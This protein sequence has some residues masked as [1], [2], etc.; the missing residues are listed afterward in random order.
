MNK[1]NV[2]FITIV[3]LVA[4]LSTAC[5]A[6]QPKPSPTALP[7]VR[8]T[9]PPTF[10]PTLPPTQAASPT[11]FLPSPTP[12]DPAKKTV[13]DFFAALA[14]KDYESAAGLYSNFSLMVDEVTRGEAAAEL[15]ARAARGEKIT[16]W[17]TVETRDFDE[18]T[19]LVH[20]VYK[21][22]VEEKATATPKAKVTPT[23]TAEAAPASMDEWWPVRLENGQWRYNRNNLIDFQTLDTP[24]Q[25]TGGL[26]VKP[27][28]LTRYSDHLRLTLL[29]QN[30]TNETIVLG[31][32]NEVMAVFLFG[33][34][35][36]EADKTRLIFERLRSYPDTAIE[37]KGLFEEYPDGIIIRQ[38][39]GLKVEPWYTFEF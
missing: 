10:A 21:V 3:I 23:A 8:L 12:Y 13:E 6:M 20:V 17:E 37:L 34:K 22:S 26:T 19:R 11:P 33:D 28:Q 38:W 25:T 24:T 15:K 31:Q 14:E 39:K 36:V 16:N 27:R 35:P 30:Q 1:H 2:F 5:G 9:Q 18:R 29:V 32:P 4:W 7:P